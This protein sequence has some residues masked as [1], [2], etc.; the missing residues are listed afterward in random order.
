MWRGC[1]GEERLGKKEEKRPGQKDEDGEV[2]K[3]RIK[4]KEGG[5]TK[6]LAQGAGGGV[7]EGDANKPPARA[8][9]E[10]GTPAKG[11]D[12]TLKEKTSRKQTETGTGWA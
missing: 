5:D 10:R 6:S 4:S 11:N 2:L 1:E 12:L 7:R 3:Q 9:K 8:P